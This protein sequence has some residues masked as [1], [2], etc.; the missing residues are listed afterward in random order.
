MAGDSQAAPTSGPQGDCQGLGGGCGN[1]RCAMSAAPQL[2]MVW[3]ASNAQRIVPT[4]GSEVERKSATQ[5]EVKAPLKA[6]ETCPV[7]SVAL[8]RRHTEKML[9]RYLYASME[10]G[11]APAILDEPIARGW[12]SIQ[13]PGAHLRGCGNLCS[14]LRELPESAWIAGPSNAAARCNPGVYAD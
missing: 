3:D 11:R 6:P 14:R 1:R 9:G 2:P 7:V 8:Y 13:P 12:V 4:N 10:V 5:P